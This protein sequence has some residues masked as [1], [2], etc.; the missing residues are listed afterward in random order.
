[1]VE[2]RTV[3]AVSAASAAIAI[4]GY[5]VYFDYKRRNDPEFRKK[6]RKEKKKAA[7]NAKEVETETPPVPGRSPEELKELLAKIGAEPLPTLP[8][9]R[10][11]YFMEHVGIGEQMLLRGPAFEVPAAL[12]FY[13]ALRA[14]PAPMEIIVIFQNT[15]PPQIFALVMQLTSLDVELEGDSEA[16]AE[17][18]ADNMSE[19]EVVSAAQSEPGAE[20]P[21]E[22]VPEPG[23]KD[24]TEAQDLS[25]AEVA[26][27]AAESEPEPTPAQ[28][29]EPPVPESHQEPA[30]EPES[31]GP[32]DP[33]A[34]PL[35]SDSDDDTRSDV[36]SET[37]SYHQTKQR[38]EGYYDVFPPKNMNVKIVNVPVKDKSGKPAESDGKPILRSALVSAKEI[39][40]GDVIYMEKA[41]VAVLDFDLQNLRTHCTHCLRRV[42]VPISVPDDPLDASYCSKECQTVSKIHSQ[43]VLFGL[44]PPVP[45]NPDE[46]E[47]PKSEAELVERRKSQ[48]EF[49]EILRKAG[50]TRALLVAR[51]IASMVAEQSAKLGAAINP[52]SKNS[53]P[54]DL[55]GLPEPEGDPAA[56]SFYDHVERLKYLEILE[57]P[58]ELEEV[59][60]LKKVMRNAMEGLEEF[61]GDR[62]PLLKG[63]LAYNVIGVAFGSGRDDKPPVTVR[64]ED[65][66]RTRTPHGTSRQTGSAFYRVS[67]YL[68]HSCTPNVAPSFHTGTSDLHLVANEDIP[69]GTELTMAY[70]D[71][72]QGPT[73]TRLEAR[74]RR[75]QELARGW[76]FACE[77][78]RC[79]KE[80]EEGILNE[81]KNTEGNDAAKEENLELGPEA[82]LED[83]VRR[84]ETG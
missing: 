63:K 1:M 76:R 40:A 74:R 84:Y 49:V 42:D 46:P 79:L 68:A 15:L 25:Y 27:K 22:I 6:L 41:I 61:V 70:V 72:N 62:Y 56:Y 51:F 80:V 67:S 35:G 2:T 82:K 20:S 33:A 75:R 32:R 65:I 36:H 8:A 5:I 48:E 83:A 60:A 31:T 44:D 58:I 55:F 13:R 30:P 26:G 12:A 7:K 52:S 28:G 14:Y 57:T 19:P 53:S 17:T 50:A 24:S 81:D 37:D 4:A 34:V 16:E 59:N 23:T 18:K 78:P 47:K 54:A 38:A 43:N 64:P 3:V 73:E 21:P 29:S 66:E 45:P 39:K 9:E 10:E 69:E 71:V 77:C 11:K